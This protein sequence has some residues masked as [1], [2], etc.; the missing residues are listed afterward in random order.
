M[1]VVK[2]WSGLTFG[3]RFVPVEIQ[4]TYGAGLPAF[5]MVGMV[6]ESVEESK[7]RVRYALKSVGKSIPQ[8]RVMVAFLPSEVTK[9][10]A[11]FD[12]ALL[13]GFLKGNSERLIVGEVALDGTVRATV[14]SL[15]VIAAAYNSG[16]KKFICPRLPESV[17]KLMPDGDFFM[18]EHVSQLLSGETSTAVEDEGGT[19][20]QGRIGLNDVK[21]SGIK[22]VAMI[23]AAGWHHVLLMG[24]PGVGKSM[25]AERMV[26]IMPS[27]SNSEKLDLLASTGT[28]P[29]HR[30][31]RFTSWNSTPAG[32]FGSAK[33]TPGEVTFA[34]RGVLIMDEFPQYRKDI[35]EG[36]R[37]VLDCRTVLAS[38]GS[39]RLTWPADFLLVATSNPCPCGYLGHPKKVCKDSPTSVM[40]YLGRLSGPVADRIDM[41]YW[42]KADEPNEDVK[43]VEERVCNVWELQKSRWE[44]E[45]FIHAGHIPGERVDEL[46]EVG[47]SVRK[48]LDDSVEKAGLSRRERHK[49]LRL[50][51]TIADL[52]EEHDIGINHLIEAISYRQVIPWLR[53]LVP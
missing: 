36:L 39:Q 49:I 21:G 4:I 32:F 52:E 8:G 46:V 16:T 23:A 3:D 24:N 17:L 42:V 20:C 31:A 33:G 47:S 35:L 19:E 14:Q 11:H 1:D 10:G 38:Y 15:R 37:T 2:V 9:S 26:G 30:P 29:D 22:R 50:S 25:V 7:E 44:S 40:R 43:A 13:H 41:H 18:V 27:M 6:S 51:R 12:L 5:H 45:G 28:L 48:L 53:S 34:H